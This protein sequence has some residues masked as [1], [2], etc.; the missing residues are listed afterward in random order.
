MVPKKIF[1]A[2]TDANDWIA[3]AQVGG[4]RAAESQGDFLDLKYKQ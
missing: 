4:W 1:I 2:S 3:L